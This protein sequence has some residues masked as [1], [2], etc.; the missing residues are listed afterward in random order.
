MGNLP[1]IITIIKKGMKLPFYLFAEFKGDEW[2]VGYRRYYDYEDP[3]EEFVFF[4][5][6]LKSALKKLKREI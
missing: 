2:K 1:E 4:D 6:N 5:K 3:I